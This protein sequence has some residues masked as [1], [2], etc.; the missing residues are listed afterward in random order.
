[1]HGVSFGVYLAS[2]TLASLTIK[3]NAA[4][5]LDDRESDGHGGYLPN[6][7]V[8]GH[9]IQLNGVSLPKG[10]EISWNEMT[11]SDGEASIEDV[12]NFYQSHGS[13]GNVI[14]VHDNYLQ[15]A[16]A[17]G[18][19]TPYTGAGIQMD[20]SSNDSSTATGFVQVQKNT[21]IHLAG[22]GISI[23]AGH[24][25]AVTDNRI[26]S[27]GKDSSGNWLGG[28]GPSALVMSN[29]YRTN[30]YFNNSMANN[31]GGLVR[32]NANGN[33]SP[34][35]IYAPSAS[36]TLNNIVGPNLF[37]QPCVAGSTLNLAAESNER[38]RWLSTVAAA[39]E[40][41]GDQH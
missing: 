6:Q 1:M 4:D 26:V 34:G 19:T 36:E 16:F 17:A 35:D 10:G 37:E 23:A 33:P 40:L 11:N 13:A 8:L 18:Q 12:I 7:R 5:S 15:G 27:C 9:F 30:Q 31:S 22:D 29:Y 14:L 24:D 2:S 32:P 25:I 39:G 3:D 21:I 41:L 20:G 38:K 28:S